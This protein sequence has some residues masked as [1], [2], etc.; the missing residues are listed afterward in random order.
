MFDHV[1]IRVSDPAASERFYDTVL[2]AIG[3]EKTGSAGEFGEGC[4]E[5]AE[6]GDFSIAAADEDNPATTGLHIGFCAWSHEA[7]QA[8]W[9]A[10]IDAGFRSDGEPG[11]RPV[12]GDDYYGGFLLD[13]DGNSAEA[14]LHDGLK[15]QG[16]IDHLWIRVGDVRATAAFYEAV[17][18]FTGFALSRELPE[19]THFRGPGAQFALVDDGGPATQHLHVAFP[20]ASNDTVDAFHAAALAAG[21]TDN[22]PPGERPRY[23][24]GYYGAFVLDPAGTNVEVV[25]HNR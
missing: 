22:G 13:P 6:W 25:N 19:R 18:P 23:H 10:G 7:V 20:A 17:A 21:Y 8:F 4:A 3:V 24:P 14:A 12:Y 11:P 1:T 2:A 5:L 16:N 15:R 9:Q